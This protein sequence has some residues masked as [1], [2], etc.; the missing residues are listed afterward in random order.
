MDFHVVSKVDNNIH[1]SFSLDRSSYPEPKELSPDSARVQP[2]V[3]SLTSNNLSYARFGDF[4]HWWDAYPVPATAP[5][6]YND[7]T[8][9]GIVPAWGY[10]IVTESTINSLKPGTLLFGFWPTSSAPVD[11]KLSPS[12]PSGNWVEISEHRKLQM[13][14]YNE[15]KETGHYDLP[16][17][18]TVDWPKEQ[19]DNMAWT[20]LLGTVWQTGYL[21]N[22]YS[23]TTNPEVDPNIG[24]MGASTPWSKEDA[25]LSEAVLVNLSA[26]GK[27]ARGFAWQVLN[28]RSRGDGPLGF[29]Q[30]TQAP[31]TIGEVA[32]RSAQNSGTP[33]KASG[34]SDIAGGV[35]WAAGLKPKKLVIIDFGARD[36]AVKKLVESVNESPEL[37]EVKTVIIHV[38]SE[39]KVYSKEEM[40]A[41]L[42]DMQMLGKVRCNT[43]DILDAVVASIGRQAYQDAVQSNWNEW[44][45]ERENNIP[46]MK[47][48]WSDSV[49]GEHGIHGGWDRVTTGSL[50]PHECL[51]FKFR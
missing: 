13:S 12:E 8:K 3:I 14:I 39:Q 20:A 42:Q 7:K 35:E 18:G 29:L 50:A 40:M 36:N 49:F 4:L 6:P 32:K 51:V 46:D 2:V 15:Y 10:G 1:E 24:P 47:L 26:S 30:I 19:L 45:Q 17:S 16:T 48:T 41:Y 9:W 44:S 33:T 28:K 37:K 43:A 23:F 25:D 31:E 5:A 27:T 34:Y 21:L 38:G 22:K 11:L